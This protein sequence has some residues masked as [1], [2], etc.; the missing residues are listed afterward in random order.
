MIRRT[1][2]VVLFSLLFGT[3]LF[4]K[5]VFIS[6]TGKANGFFSDARIFNPS[7]TK[8][9]TVNAQYLPFGNINNTGAAVVP[10]V[11]PKR[12]MK[13]YDDA[14]LSMFGIT[15][16]GTQL[17]AI[18]LVSDDDFQASQRIFQD[19]RAGK[20]QGTLGQF[21]PGLP[22]AAAVRKGVILQLKSGAA[23]L[24]DFRTNWGGVNP[25]TTVA[26]I[27]FKL[28]DKNNALVGTTNLTMQPFGVF[29]PNNIFNFFGSPS[30][31][32]SDAW[33]SFESDVPVFLYGSVVDNG[34]VDPTF[35]PASE[36]TGVAPPAPQLKTVTVNAFN[37]GYTLT[38][39]APLAAGDQVR[40]V[41]QATSGTHGFSLFTPDGNNLISEN[42]VTSTPIERIVTLPQSGNYPFVCIRASCGDGH[43]DMFG[44]LT[45]P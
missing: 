33:I 6:V 28:F 31:D 39:S 32:L 1:V 7:F 15:A 17:G 16:T 23:T 45:V 37:F 20:Q 22:L 44:T 30:A 26:N 43:T 40:F 34:S 12:T 38:P 25:N 3:G 42:P 9:I 5:E 21:V 35:V 27:A 8:D 36:D 18:R 11:I 24:G 14:V 10:L 41:I 2:T 19:A 4:A 13:V 29:S